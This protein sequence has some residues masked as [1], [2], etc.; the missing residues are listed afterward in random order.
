MTRSFYRDE[1]WEST[2]VAER[3]AETLTEE[4]EN[5]FR[6]RFACLRQAGFEI[7]PARSLALDFEA[8]LRLAAD[9]LKRGCPEKTVLRIV[10]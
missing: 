1:E 9:L 7:E 4:A 6:W 2:P 5:L 10:L 3:Y 8:D